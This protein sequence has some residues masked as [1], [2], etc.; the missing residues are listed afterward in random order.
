M[1]CGFTAEESL[2]CLPEFRAENRVD[3]GVERGVEVTEPEEDAQHSLVENPIREDGHEEG[4]DEKGEPAN[5]ESSRDDGQRFGRFSLS[6]SL[7]SFS[8]LLDRF[9][10]LL[11]IRLWDLCLINLSSRVDGSGRRN[12]TVARQSDR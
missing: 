7:E 4:A 1:N 8:F 11:M 12:R 2:E 9:G 5:D 3:D 10:R 6:F